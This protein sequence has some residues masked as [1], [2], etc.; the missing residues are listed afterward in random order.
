MCR[1][2]IS[3]GLNKL[4]HFKENASCVRFENAR[5]RNQQIT[6]RYIKIEG[7]YLYI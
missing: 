6:E 1:G 5:K 4:S 3:M 2:V 7:K